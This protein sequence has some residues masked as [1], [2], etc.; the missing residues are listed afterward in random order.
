MGN[1]RMSRMWMPDQLHHR[2][3]ISSYLSFIILFILSI[4]VYY[5]VSMDLVI[6]PYDTS[7][8]IVLVNTSPTPDTVY[9]ISSTPLSDSINPNTGVIPTPINVLSLTN[10]ITVYPL[11]PSSSYQVS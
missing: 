7:I 4:L 9:L 5:G 8:V 11:V 1:Y 10:N 6:T 3:L 2:S